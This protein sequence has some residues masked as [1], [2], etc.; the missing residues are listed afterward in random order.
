[1]SAHPKRSECP[2]NHIWFWN[3]V[4]FSVFSNLDSDC[5]CLVILTSVSS[6]MLPDEQIPGYV[7]SLCL[8]KSLVP[9]LYAVIQEQPSSE[10]QWRNSVFCV[11]ERMYW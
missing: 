1:M 6:Q 11:Y 4:P 3:E 10:V 5:G 2:I 7:D 8:K 9:A